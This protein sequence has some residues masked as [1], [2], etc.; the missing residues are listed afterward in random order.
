MRPGGGNSIST[1]CGRRTSWPT[2][3][4]KFSTIGINGTF[5]SLQRPEF[6]TAWREATPEGFVFAVKGARFITRARPSM[7]WP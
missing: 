5:Y 7:P 6:F 2:P 3:A 1:A 4:G